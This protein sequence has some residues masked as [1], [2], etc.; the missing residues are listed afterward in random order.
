MRALMLDPY[1]LLFDEPLAALDP[2]VRS[3]V[4]ADLK[5]IFKILKKTV[6]WVTHDMGEASYFGDPIVLLR[7]GR[8]V[9]SGTLKALINSPAN[10]FVTRF[11]N[12]QR[13]PLESTIMDSL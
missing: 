12:A 1:V 4:Q 5:R 11:I 6:V 7:E 3:D 9:Q 2:M 13:S 8:I 10:P